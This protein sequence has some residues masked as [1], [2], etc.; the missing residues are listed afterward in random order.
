MTPKP[1]FDAGPCFPGELEHTGCNPRPGLVK[2][3]F[4]LEVAKFLHRFVLDWDKTCKT[5]CSTD[6]AF[7]LLDRFEFFRFSLNKQRSDDLSPELQIVLSAASAPHPHARFCL[8]SITRGASQQGAAR[9]HPLFPP[10]TPPPPPDPLRRQTGPGLLW[11]GARLGSQPLNV[12]QTDQRG[13]RCDL[14]LIT[15]PRV[16][17]P[18]PVNTLFI[19]PSSVAPTVHFAVFL[20]FFIANHY[21]LSPPTP[22]QMQSGDVRDRG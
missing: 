11:P 4:G 8:N 7:I 10:P 12:E 3:K 2:Q 1:P 6:V 22:Q 21:L 17:T 5:S 16:T 14:E 18:T 15:P 19:H 9:W 13:A 20:F